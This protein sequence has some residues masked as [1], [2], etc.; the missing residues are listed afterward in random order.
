M[1][2]ERCQE[3][4]AVEMGLNLTLQMMPMWLQVLLQQLVTQSS[5][6][7][8]ESFQKNLAKVWHSEIRHKGPNPGRG[9]SKLSHQQPA[10][11]P[12]PSWHQ[13]LKDRP[14]WQRPISPKFG[15][16]RLH[17]ESFC[18]SLSWILT[19]ILKTGRRTICSC[20]CALRRRAPR[21]TRRLWVETDMGQHAPTWPSRGSACSA[22]PSRASRR[23]SWRGS[24]AV[25]PP[26]PRWT[27][28]A[29]SAP[30]HKTKE[31]QTM[32]LG[33]PKTLVLQK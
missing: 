27:T 3:V 17:S 20:S 1:A 14:F 4:A 11:A 5:T 32:A 2:A 22:P 8:F 25:P 24:P 6:C 33:I 21:G 31:T 19:S 15:S 10:A 7:Q 29:R 18:A 30:L 12:Q 13:K 26:S 9:R 28:T 16:V 23:P